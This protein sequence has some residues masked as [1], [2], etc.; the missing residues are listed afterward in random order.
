MVDLG[1]LVAQCA[2]LVAPVTAHAVITVE[3]AGD[4]HAIGVVGGRLVRQPRS[5]AEA[6]ATVKSLETQGMNYSVG[7]G[8]INRGN[9]ARLG[10]TPET[11]F[12][13]CANLRAMQVILGECFERA[14]R[15][16]EGEQ[17]A[18]KRALS[19]YYSGN[20]NTGFE[21]GYVQRV[22]QVVR[23]MQ[24]VAPKNQAPTAPQAEQGTGRSLNKEG[25][26]AARAREQ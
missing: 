8:Q 25:E 4:P 6:L 19:C 12:E 16:S 23:S 22:V 14:G 13:P 21:Q 26:A 15:V 5:R 17:L 20:F 2:P 1:V 10:L 3:S 9:F 7:L 11:A 24:A 18:L